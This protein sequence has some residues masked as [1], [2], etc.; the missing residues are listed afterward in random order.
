[1]RQMHLFWL[2]T[3]A[4]LPDVTLVDLVFGG[5]HTLFLLV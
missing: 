4:S 1:M 5:R 2:D 3:F